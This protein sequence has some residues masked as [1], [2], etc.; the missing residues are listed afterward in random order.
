MPASGQEQVCHCQYTGLALSRGVGKAGVL[1]VAHLSARGSYL[2]VKYPLLIFLAFACNLLCTS[3][4]RG[5]GMQHTGVTGSPAVT[6]L[7]Q[8]RQQQQLLSLR[9][10]AAH[11]PWCRGAWHPTGSIHRAG[12]RAPLQCPPQPHGRVQWVLHSCALSVVSFLPFPSHKAVS[13]F[14]CS[15]TV[16]LSAEGVGTRRREHLRAPAGAE[17]SGDTRGGSRARVAGLW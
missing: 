3:F 8:M 11:T 4:P 13:S 5:K 10:P 16:S 14:P 17:A 1:V 15:R 6:S 12:T 2:Q 7:G 9:A